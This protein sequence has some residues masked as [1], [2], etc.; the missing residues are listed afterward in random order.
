[1]LMTFSDCVE[2]CTFSRV[3]VCS[4]KHTRMKNRT[5]PHRR[6]L[7]HAVRAHTHTA[8]DATVSVCAV[9]SPSPFPKCWRVCARCMLHT[10]A[11]P[12]TRTHAHQHTSS[13]SPVVRQHRMCTVHIRACAYPII[14]N[15]PGT[16]HNGWRVHSVSASTALQLLLCG[17]SNSGGSTASA[18]AVAANANDFSVRMSRRILIL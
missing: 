18:A 17:G 7:P 16:V 9:A 11:Q 3:R 2:M 6:E 12:R 15:V 1:M 4:H 13:S 14:I 5:R 8:C 10:T